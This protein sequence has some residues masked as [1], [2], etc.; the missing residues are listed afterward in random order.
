MASDRMLRNLCWTLAFAA[1]VAAV[2]QLLLTFNLWAGGPTQPDPQS[3]LVTHLEAFRANDV[4]SFPIA[5]GS[6]LAALVA[7]AVIGVIGVALRPRAESATGRDAMATLLLIGGV[8]GVVAMA[9]A[10]AVT[11]TSTFGYCDCGFKNE[12]LIAQDYALTVG[13]IASAWV[14]NAALALVGFGVWLAGKVVSVST[15]WRQLSYAI[16]LILIISVALRVL[17]SYVSFGEIDLFHWT[18]VVI[19]LTIAILVPIWAI[20]LA[21]GPARVEAV[22]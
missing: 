15:W 2:L 19:N 8:T 18:D 22:A 11:Q 13:F 12:E 4:E 5:F 17:A 14:F 1:I 6:S 7:F 21:R 10:L 20:L 16:A 9:M 3:D